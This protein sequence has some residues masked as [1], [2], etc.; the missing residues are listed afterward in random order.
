[1]RG[2]EIDSD[3]YLVLLVMKKDRRESRSKG[4]EAKGHLK[5]SVRK[6]RETKCR[7][8][9][10]RKIAKKFMNSR[11]CQG[12]SVEMAWDELKG[13][14][15]EVA[16]EVCRVSRKKRG[17]NRTKWWNK[18]VKKAVAARK[19]AYRNMLEVETD[20][21]RQR[22][23]EAKREAKWVVTRAKNEEWSDLGIELEADAQG[24]QKRFWSKVRS[25][26]VGEEKRYAG[27]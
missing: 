6:L 15:V 26:E 19:I 1:M 27:K 10:E 24:G 11:Y 13:A 8:E 14:V 4:P 12:S 18:E 5:W 16:S 9:F 17:T 20:E 7:K 25:W 3:H 2:A 21:S 23:V 22:Y